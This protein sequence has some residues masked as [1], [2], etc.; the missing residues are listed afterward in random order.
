M[1]T[2]VPGARPDAPPLVVSINFD[3]G[4]V[5]DVTAASMLEARGMRGTFF[6]ISGYMSTS[7]L[8]VAGYVS[9]DQLRAMQAAGHEIGG[10]TAT[11]SH[12]PALP[13]GDALRQICNDRT[14]LM[15]YG[16]DIQSLAYPFGETAPSVETSAAACGY[17]S[18]RIVGPIT[19]SDAPLAETIPPEDVYAIMTPWSV[20]STMSLA[21]IEDWVTS[22]QSVG[23]WLPIVFHHLCDAAPCDQYSITTANFG[24]FL[25]WLAIQPNTTVKTMRDVVGGSTSPIVWLSNPVM[26]ASLESYL[27][28]SDDT[29]DWWQRTRS[30]TSSAVWTKTTDAHAGSYAQ[31]VDISSMSAG[32][33]QRLVPTQR[34][35]SP[36]AIPGHTYHLSAWYESSLSPQWSLYYRDQSGA[37][38]WWTQ[39]PALPTA[40]SWT[41]ATFDTPPVPAG[42]TAID[43]GL[44]AYSTGF[45][46]MDD[47][48]MEDRGW[49][50]PGV[51]ITSPV[52][53]SSVR[54]TIH[55]TANGTAF[56]GITHVDFFVNGVY[57]T[58]EVTAPYTITLDTSTIPDGLT[59][60]SATA[61]D[62][63]GAS[64]TS[65]S[66]VYVTNG[67]G[68]LVNPYLESDVVPRDGVP[69]CW[70]RVTLVAGT[71]ATFSMTTDA[72]SGTY[73]ERIDVTTLGGPG[74]GAR[75]VPTLD[76][77][78]NSGQCA[79]LAT[80]GRTYQVAGWYK[81]SSPAAQIRW[82]FLYR[83]ASGVWTWWTQSPPL[84]AVSAWTQSTW[85][86]PAL[87]AGATAVSLGLT[88]YNTAG[89]LTVDDFTLFENP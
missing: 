10:H 49:A 69:D 72:H 52:D 88:L 81:S 48:A 62:N 46:A 5:E 82:V 29:P 74:A 27:V 64:A 35:C 85:T 78:A 77:V 17:N 37:W 30:G 61:H 47:F 65:T 57:L 28:A 14:T 39:S 76:T 86:T 11:H 67:A 40:S 34:T 68:L 66:Q 32:G 60:L 42:A 53:G 13:A 41:Q 55:V 23:G 26:N 80:P 71:G 18:A 51:T 21:E 9:V 50:P 45:L 4:Y 63:M 20:E 2:S 22:A 33:W 70:Q 58:T 44:S 25:D 31:R 56:S 36:P 19:D 8:P 12:L 89:I 73:A 83:N 59:V 84:P 87:P 6:V 15:N 38:V 1:V 3:D 16:L 79:P 7:G 54:G 24:A 75:L 43:F